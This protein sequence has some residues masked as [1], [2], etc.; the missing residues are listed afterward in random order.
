MRR[1]LSNTIRTIL[2]LVLALSFLAGANKPAQAAECVWEGD[3]SADWSNP[4]NWSCGRVPIAED[5]VSISSGTPPNQPTIP[6][7]Y[8]VTVNSITINS[9]ATL[10]IL[11]GSVANAATWTI[12]G[13]LVANATDSPIALNSPPW[14]EGGVMNVSSTGSI[15]KLGADDLFIYAA[16]NNDGSVIFTESGTYTGGVVLY[17]GGS[18]TGIFQGEYL[19]VGDNDSASG[20]IFNFNS[21][22]EIRVNQ[23]HARG[24]TVNLYGTYSQPENTG[25]YLIVQPT[26]GTSTVY[27]K[28]G[29]GILKTPENFDINYGG[30]LILESQAYNYNMSKLRLDYNGELQNLGNLSVST[31][32]LWGAGK[33]TGNGTTT[34]DA[35]ATFTMGTSSYTQNDFT[36]NNQTL[37]NNSTANWNKRDLTLTNF[38]TFINNGTFNANATTTM[39]G[40]ETEVFTNNGSFI[41]NTAATTTTM[42]VPFTNNGTVDVVAGSLVFPQGMDNGEDAVIDLGGGT[43]DPG[44]ELNLESGDSLIG[45]GTLSANL[46]NA[47]T[48]SPGAS[49]GIITVEGDYTQTVNGILEIEL[50]GTTLGIEYDQ[51]VVTGTATMLYGT[52][53]VTLEPGYTPQEGDEFLIIDHVTGTGTF[54]YGTVTLPDLPGG[55]EL[56]INFSDPGVTLT[57]VSG[58]TD[59]Y[60]Y[61]P[62]IVR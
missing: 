14:S 28:T 11:K 32:F 21:G 1:P 15:T 48:V 49:P 31:Q 19:F 18:H 33:I 8:L 52:L 53:N 4:A 23:L 25:T 5:D 39:T 26:S 44:D 20:Q 42:N 47:G 3:T 2:V 55:L 17:R 7:T 16:L 62:M 13:A 24:G 38:A 40:T 22:S 61:L 56:E 27:F 36:L 41:K 46:V 6:A 29:V 59:T 37:I 10:T 51:L 43:L 9:G 50:G 58:S 57:V 12:N 45:S 60:I 30:K 54:E 35:G 34:V